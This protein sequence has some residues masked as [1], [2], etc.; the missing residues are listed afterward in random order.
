MYPATRSPCMEP[1]TSTKKTRGSVN[2][3]PNAQH[4]IANRSMGSFSVRFFLKTSFDFV[5]L[6]LSFETE[7]S[8]FPEGTSATETP[9]TRIALSTAV[10]T[11]RALFEGAVT[12]CHAK[13]STRPPERDRKDK[14]KPNDPPTSTCATA[15]T[16]NMKSP[17]VIGVAVKVTATRVH[18]YAGKHNRNASLGWVKQSVSRV[19][20]DV[21]TT[22]TS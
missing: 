5:S 12:P 21:W 6:F 8:P 16:G 7:S 11:D 4:A 14:H 18:M 19:Y 2:V 3:F 1:S 15:L 17:T 20:R 10:A 13:L 9:G 22:V